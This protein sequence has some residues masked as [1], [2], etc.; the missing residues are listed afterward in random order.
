MTLPWP[1]APVLKP[2]PVGAGLLEEAP[3][4]GRPG[5]ALVSVST[6]GLHHQTVLGRL[7]GPGS[8]PFPQECECLRHDIQ[9]PLL[10]QLLVL[11]L[12]RGWKPLVR[13]PDSLCPRPG[14]KYSFFAITGGETE[15]PEQ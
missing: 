6:V 5:Q 2:G 3:S 7:R 15:G 10:P 12:S 4:S 13:P 11:P 8:S 1:P 14:G 9:I